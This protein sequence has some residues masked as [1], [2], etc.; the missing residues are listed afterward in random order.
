MKRKRIINLTI[1]INKTRPLN[2]RQL[3]NNETHF[4]RKLWIM[5]IAIL[6][7]C[8]VKSQIIITNFNDHVPIENGDKKLSTTT[9]PAEMI[10]NA[11]TV[12]RKN[13]KDE[14]TVDRRIVVIKEAN[15]SQL[16]DIKYIKSLGSK[17]KP[18]DLNHDSLQLK[19]SQLYIK[20]QRIKDSVIMMSNTISRVKNRWKN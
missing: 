7:S 20:I 10:G 18:D 3:L 15:E 2:N 4:K 17:F 16:E 9:K 6:I 8:S 13:Q 11:I 12:I 1:G 5:L 14:Q 19:S